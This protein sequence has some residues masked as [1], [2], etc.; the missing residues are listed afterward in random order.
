[1]SIVTWFG[2]SAGWKYD[3]C[4][5]WNHSLYLKLFTFVYQCWQNHVFCFRA[6]TW[7][8]FDIFMIFSLLC[9]FFKVIIEAKNRDGRDLLVESY[10]EYMHER[11][12]QCSAWFHHLQKN[13]YVFV[14]S[15]KLQVWFCFP[16]CLYMS[17]F[18]YL[19]GP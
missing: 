12:R 7:Q 14:W 16:V 4:W 17:C 1:M 3:W 11:H 8:P 5:F 9:L 2:A 19:C 6:L 13:K 18:I 15:N 10:F